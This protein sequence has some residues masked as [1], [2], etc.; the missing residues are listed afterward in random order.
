MEKNC[1]QYAKIKFC[2]KAGFTAA[3]M[4]EMFVKVFGDL[5]CRVL[6]YFDGIASL[7]R[8]RSQL[9]MQSRVEG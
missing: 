4:W 2:C 5:L 8:V 6:Q 9:M 1:G 7:R 3:K